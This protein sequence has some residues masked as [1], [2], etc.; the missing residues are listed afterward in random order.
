MQGFIPQLSAIVFLLAL[1]AFF[2]AAEFSIL[3]VRHSRIRQLALEGDLQARTVERLQ[4]SLDRLLSTTQLGITLSSLAL[5]WMGEKGVSQL[6]NRLF[7]ALPLP[8]QWSTYWSH[9]IA[10][11]LAFLSLVYLQII[12]GEL[13][14]KAIALMYPEDLARLLATPSTAIARIFHPFIFIL[15]QSTRFLLKLGG[16]EYDR[17]NWYSRLTP[18]ELQ[19]IISTNS[20]SIGLEDE[21]RALL[22]NVFAFGEVTAGEI[23]VPRTK[24][25]GVNLD[26]SFKGLLEEVS[27]SQHSR[28]PVLGDSL[29]DIR[30]IIC[31]K[32]LASAWVETESTWN[33]PIQ[34]WVRP[35]RFVPEYLLLSELLPLMQRSAQDMVIVVDEYGGTAGLVTI[36]DVVAEIIGEGQDAR[37]NESLRIETLNDYTFLVP[38]QMDLEEVNNIL[39]FNFPLSEEYNSLGGFLIYQLQKIPKPGEKLIYQRVELTVEKSDGPRLDLI[40]LVHLIHQ[41]ENAGM[42]MNLFDLTD[43]EQAS[44]SLSEMSEMPELPEELEPEAE[45]QPGQPHTINSDGGI[46][47]REP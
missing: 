19:L 40:R 5:G 28:Y 24:I 41:D 25:V 39:D 31:F 8:D 16:L 1:N 34:D 23:M 38:A 26:I 36:E 13:C 43:T 7:L 10:V 14:P 37:S 20:E 30:G 12:F 33:I 35:A 17:P 21:E 2:V 27:Q 47:D 45:G 9:A 4:H 44:P 18:E 32:E 29:D 22:N 3:S 11:P 6:F 46:D 15:N 42:D